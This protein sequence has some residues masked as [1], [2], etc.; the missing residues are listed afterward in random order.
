MSN[1][2]INGADLPGVP[3]SLSADPNDRRITNTSLLSPTSFRLSIARL[4]E[5][6]YFCQSAN[7]PSVEIEQINRTNMFVDIKEIGKPSFGDLSISFLI[8][9][10]MK[11]WKSVYDWMRGIAPFEDFREQIDPYADHRSDVV[12]MVTT[13]AMNPN[14][15]F[16]FKGCFPT[17]LGAVAFD[18]KAADID[19]LVADLTFAFDSFDIRLIP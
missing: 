13:G 8:D 18:S 4:P 16:T 14:V 17:S 9:E 7:I 3:S 1:F 12:L 5:V 10:D 15:E 11:N 2:G 19:P 6:T